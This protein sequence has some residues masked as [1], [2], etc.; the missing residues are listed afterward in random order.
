MNINQLCCLYIPAA[1]L[2][3]SSSRAI[4]YTVSLSGT[5]YCLVFTVCLP[6]NNLHTSF[7]KHFFINDFKEH[8]PLS[9]LYI[10]LK[11]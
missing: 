10:Y 11:G 5:V 2:R 1:V 3:C 4:P 7:Y 9:K 6:T 8:L